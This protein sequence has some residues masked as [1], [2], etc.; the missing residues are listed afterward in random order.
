MFLVSEKQ[1][2]WL[3]IFMQ[4]ITLM[5]IGQCS[6]TLQG[7]SPEL[8]HITVQMIVSESSS[9]QIL[10]QFVVPMLTIDIGLTEII[11]LDDHLKVKVIN[12]LQYLLVDI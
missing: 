11:D 3:D 7:Y 1:V 2:A 12:A 8:V 5:A 10:H 4:D 6:R 9:L